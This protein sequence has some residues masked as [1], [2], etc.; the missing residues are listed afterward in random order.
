MKTFNGLVVKNNDLVVKALDPQ[1]RDPDSKPLG[2]SKVYSAFHPS[3][4]N[5][6]STRIFGKSGKK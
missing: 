5:K 1:S 4:V 2:S 3:D 6:M